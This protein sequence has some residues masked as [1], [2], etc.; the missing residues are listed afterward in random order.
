[1]MALQCKLNFTC[2][3]CR[4]VLKDP[5]QTLCCGRHLCKG[6]VDEIEKRE[7]SACPF[8]KTEPLSC[9]Q[10]K[11]F[12]RLVSE[13][14]SQR[15]Q[16]ARQY[17]EVLCICIEPT[18]SEGDHVKSKQAEESFES[19][20]QS[21]AGESPVSSCGKVADSCPQ[22]TNESHDKITSDITSLSS[23]LSEFQKQLGA[24][25]EK[26]EQMLENQVSLLQALSRKVEVL[27][28]RVSSHALLPF[29]AVIPC[30]DSYIEGD[31]GDEWKSQ[32]FYTGTHSNKGYKLQLSVVPHSLHMRNKEKALSARLLITSGENDDRLSWPFHARFSLAF[33][34]PSGKETPYE[35]G[36]RCHT[37]VSPGDE[38]SMQF[39]A[40][41]THKEL[42]KYV[43]CDNSLHL[44]VTEHN[45]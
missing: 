44:S 4:D 2:G 25:Q 21:L 6:C 14:E 37:W 24:R 9:F 34:D 41:I 22:K 45:N 36:E 27:E 35:V 17:T 33:V 26:V 8:C 31:V 43:Q 15:A 13:L 12:G 30:I 3:R 32:E 23:K 5:Q 10:D 29:T 19:N 40:C 16:T 11:H 18:R 39:I 1:M 42:I 38:K 28:N 20:A 7:T